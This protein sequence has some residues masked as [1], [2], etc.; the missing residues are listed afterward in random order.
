MRCSVEDLNSKLAIVSRVLVSNPTIPVLSHVVFDGT[1]VYAYDGM[2]AIRVPFET[3]FQCAVPGKEFVSALATFKDGEVS[4][5]LNGNKLSVNIGRAVLDFVCLGP[6]EFAFEVPNLSEAVSYELSE[7]FFDSLKFVFVAANDN[8]D[9]ASTYGV[10]FCVSDGQAILYGTD[11]K[12]LAKAIV[13]NTDLDGFEITLPIEFCRLLLSNIK[14][15]DCGKLLFDSECGRIAAISDRVQIYSNLMVQQFVDCVAMVNKIQDEASEPFTVPKESWL[16]I[17]KRAS[18]LAKETV[19]TEIVSDANNLTFTTKTPYCLHEEHLD[20]D[21]VP[22]F[23]AKVN[24]KM[25][26]NAK[27]CMDFIMVHDL[28]V[29]YRS[30]DG[31]RLLIVANMS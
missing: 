24:P 29:V 2:Q 1:H 14:H 31:N 4:L 7:D 28:G 27:D 9:D 13:S 23:R 18:L 6:Q 3:D 8:L 15:L 21:R 20:V 17:I 16:A 25:S 12:Q 11:R 22:N 19:V 26:L 5:S 10:R 30:E